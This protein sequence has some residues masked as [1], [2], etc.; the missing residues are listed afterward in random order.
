MS[1]LVN[2]NTKQSCLNLIQDISLCWGSF[3]LL[4]QHKS[5]VFS[6]FHWIKG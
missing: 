4:N 2:K 5:L 6:F 3:L 1:V